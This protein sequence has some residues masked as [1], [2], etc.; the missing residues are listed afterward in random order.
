MPDVDYN[1]AVAQA[2]KTPQ[3]LTTLLVAL[4]RRHFTDEAFFWDPTTLYL[5]IRSEFKVDP[6]VEVMDRLSAA[7]VII[8]GDAFFKQLDGF[9]HIANVLADGAAS[10]DMFDP[11]TVEE[12]G[13]ALVEVSLL[14]D[15]L[16]LGYSVKQYIRTILLQD[17]YSEEDYPEVFTEALER[18]P[19]AE[20][21]REAG[22]R[23]LH[24]DQRDAFEEFINDQLRDLIYQ[25]NKIPGMASELHA[26]MK[27]KELEE[28]SEG[29]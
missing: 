10:F 25:F 13:W 16:P 2:F 14:R 23:T 11:V 19:V 20:D 12:A 22:E 15:M 5:E 26:M 17:G 7:Q 29:I 28:L 9:F 27:E 24:D 21:I 3:T 6:P 4:V 1:T 18:I 8:T